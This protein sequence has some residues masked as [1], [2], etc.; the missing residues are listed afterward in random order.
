MNNKII[1]GKKVSLELKEKIIER[2]NKLD[3]KLKLA[4]IQVGNNEASTIYVNSK[5]KLA[6]SMNIDFLLLHYDSIGEKELI[7]KIEELNQDDDVTSILVQLPLP[8]GLNQQKIIDAIDPKKDVD[9]LTSYNLNQRVNGDE[10]IIPCTTL[11]ILYLL[12]YYGISLEGKRVCLIGRSRLVGFPTYIEL[13]KRNATITT[14]HSKTKDLGNIVKGNDIIISA[15]GKKHLIDSS[16]IK[17]GAVVID[18]GITRED[19]LYGDVFFDD[20]INK[21]S[22]ITPVPGGVGPMTAIMI[23]NNVL[24]CHNLQQK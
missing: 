4:V 8:D 7:K 23:I 20:V 12:D 5:R 13:L 19:K 21:C 15:T 9:G 17:E 16:M 22:Y 6:L 18:V 3:K 24:E 2:I 1:D 14:C 11:G 10:G